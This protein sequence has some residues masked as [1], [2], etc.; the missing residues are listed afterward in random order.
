MSCFPE[1]SDLKTWYARCVRACCLIGPKTCLSALQYVRTEKPV[2]DMQ[3]MVEEEALEAL[4]AYRYVT[5]V[6]ARTPDCSK[7]TLFERSSTWPTQ[8]IAALS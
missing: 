2:C 4:S 3:G 1:V 7:A 6:C 5:V 8:G